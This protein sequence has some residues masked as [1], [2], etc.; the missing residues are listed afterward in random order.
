MRSR[1]IARAGLAALATLMALG[2]DPA[3][4]AEPVV[5]TPSASLERAERAFA[6]SAAE[7]NVADAFLAVLAE[8][9]VVFRPGPVNGRERFEAAPASDALL[10]WEPKVVETSADGTLGFTTGPFRFA[11]DRS[12][13]AETLH[14]HYFSVWRRSNGEAWRLVADIGISH[15][16]GPVVSGRTRETP[17]TPAPGTSLADLVEVERAGSPRCAD[18]AATDLR[19]YRPDRPPVEGIADGCDLVD[20]T[21]GV[22]V[23]E[24]VGGE[25]ATSGDLGF[26]YGAFAGATR[27]AYVHVWRR[28][29]GGW[30]LLVDVALPWPEPDAPS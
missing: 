26:T 24:P 17:G 23:A 30:R 29:E 20:A 15:A 14:G 22:G 28:E 2:C 21:T 12:G 3:D 18:R 6:R 7:G 10:E 1:E 5:E 27:H 4:V 9:G 19:V 25:V 16:P 11:P 13:T 8:D